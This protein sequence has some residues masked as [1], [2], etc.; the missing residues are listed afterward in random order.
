[1]KDFSPKG[2]WKTGIIIVMDDDGNVY[3]NNKARHFAGTIKEE[4][5]SRDAIYMMSTALREFEAEEMTDIVVKK[6]SELLSKAK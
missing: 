1:M 4:A 5:N 6:L 3:V 2:L